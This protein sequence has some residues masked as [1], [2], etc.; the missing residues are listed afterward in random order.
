MQHKVLVIHLAIILMTKKK[1]KFFVHVL[2]K[3]NKHYVHATFVFYYQHLLEFSLRLD[4]A[5]NSVKKKPKEDCDE[6][7]EKH[8]KNCLVHHIVAGQLHVILFIF[9]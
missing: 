9:P 7:E 2:R 3:A 8:Q 4:C 6:R 5:Q 1:L